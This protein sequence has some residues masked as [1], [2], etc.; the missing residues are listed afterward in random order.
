[1][2]DDEKKIIAKYI[3]GMLILSGIFF[4]LLQDVKKNDP[5]PSKEI[6]ARDQLYNIMN[7][8]YLWYDEMPDVDKSQYDTPEELL[9]AM[10]YLPKDIYSYTMSKQEYESKLIEGKYIGHGF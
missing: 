4:C 8:W 9:E 1:L 7:E 10:K 3:T 2:K 6:K 5:L